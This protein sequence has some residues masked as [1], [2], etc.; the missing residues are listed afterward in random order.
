MATKTLEVKMKKACS[1][2][3]TRLTGK[4]DPSG[5]TDEEY[6]KLIADLAKLTGRPAK[7]VR[8]SVRRAARTH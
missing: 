4:G 7:Y 5:K 2:A 1:L 6:S 8:A 3:R